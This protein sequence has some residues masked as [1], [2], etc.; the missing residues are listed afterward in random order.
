MTK[1]IDSSESK[2]PQWAAVDA[3]IRS[4]DALEEHP[5]FFKDPAHMAKVAAVED[6]VKAYF[7]VHKAMYKNHRVNRGRPFTVV[8]V[9]RPVYPNHLPKATRAA[10]YELPLAN[11][12][13]EIV[14]SKNTN[15]YLYRVY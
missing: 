13:V 9:E 4:A 2:A 11:L 14:F 12:G 6:I 7:T 3:H 5:G 10:E 15:S 1:V 8:K